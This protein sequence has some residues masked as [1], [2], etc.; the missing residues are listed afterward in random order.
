VNINVNQL[1]VPVGVRKRGFK[2]PVWPEKQHYRW[3]ML[4][5]HEGTHHALGRG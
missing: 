4:E 1:I 3:S 2:F 5:I